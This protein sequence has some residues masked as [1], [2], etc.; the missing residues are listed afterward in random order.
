MGGSALIS[1]PST[2]I[3][4][5]AGSPRRR[6]FSRAAVVPDLLETNDEGV[7]WVRFYLPV[8]SIREGVTDHPRSRN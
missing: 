8:G 6:K 2:P 4:G 7:Q 5:I 3:L 1:T